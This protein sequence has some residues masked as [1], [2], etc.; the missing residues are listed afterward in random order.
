[1]TRYLTKDQVVEINKRLILEYSSE[2]IIGVKDHS[3]LESAIHRPKQTVF[4]DDAYK[5][6]HEKAG[7][8]FHSIVKNH[9]FHNANK[10]TAL[11]VLE[12]FLTINGVEFEMKGERAEDFVVDVVNDIYTFEEICKV[13]EDHSA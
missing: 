2:E 4:G 11:V 6:I 3:M 8:L 9:A 7:A 12:I 5:T 1:M 13:L 10:R